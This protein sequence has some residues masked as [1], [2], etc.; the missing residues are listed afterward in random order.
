L[1]KC[2]FSKDSNW[3]SFKV[4][5]IF[6]EEKKLCWKEIRAVGWLWNHWSLVSWEKLV[7]RECS[8]CRALSWCEKSCVTEEVPGGAQWHSG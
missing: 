5:F 6:L 1:N 8:V 3:Y 7:D 4:T 2:I